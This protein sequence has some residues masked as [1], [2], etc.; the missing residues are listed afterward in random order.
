MKKTILFTGGG[1]AGHVV[2]NLPLIDYFK[3]KNFNI[4]YVGSET[5]MECDIIRKIQ[6]PYYPIK[7]GK[8]RRSL[9]FKNFFSPFQVMIGAWQSYFLIRKT[10]PFVIF[11]KGGFVSFP[12]VL[13]GWLN[14]IPVCIHESDM[15][16]GLANRLSFPFAKKIFITFE[17]AQKHF[18]NKKDIEFVGT[19]LRNVFFNANA[20]KGKE[21]CGFNNNKAMILVTGGGQGALRINIALRKS[22]KPLLEKYNVF[23]IC[24]KGK[25]DESLRGLS[26]YKQVEYVDEQ[27]FDLIA[28][29]TLVISRAGSN[30]AYEIA[31]MKKLNILIPVQKETRGDQIQNALY[32][33]H[34]GISKVLDELKF[35]DENMLVETINEVIANHQQYE[36]ALEKQNFKDATESIYNT[37]IQFITD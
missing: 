5:G 13:A 20:E 2:P 23:H 22:L 21:Y 1:T 8:L 24:G 29:A 28:Y 4:I 37:L 35:D 36:A 14:R 17:S 30:S 33:E 11:S 32:F 3:N 27:M 6:V 19:P 7:T 12:V 34:L 10:K 15:T 25:I 31:A 26:D 9:S 18:L 16:P